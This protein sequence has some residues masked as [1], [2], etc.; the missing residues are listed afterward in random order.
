MRD[1]QA[2]LKREAE[3]LAGITRR[4]GVDAATVVSV[5]GVETDYGRVSGRYP[6]VD[7]TLSRACLNL[8]SRERRA[9]FFAALQLLQEGQ[10]QPEAFRGSWAGAF[11]LTQFMPGTFLQ[12]R[13]DGDGSGAVDIVGSVPDALATTRALPEEP[14]LGGRPALGCRGPVSRDLVPR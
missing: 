1:G 5:F 14:G 9:H 3:P 2:I 8:G 7:A 11:G 13:E 10:V 4:L 6:V 12:H